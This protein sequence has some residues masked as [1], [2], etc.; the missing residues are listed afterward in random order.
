MSP[1]SWIALTGPPAECL[2][3]R[4][5][6][7]R[8]HHVNLP[9]NHGLA[10]AISSGRYDTSYFIS[11]IVI[12]PDPRSCDNSTNPPQGCDTRSWKKSQSYSWKAQTLHRDCMS[13]SITCLSADTPGFSMRIALP[14]CINRSTT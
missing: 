8:A 13:W 6:V 11:A 10:A 7:Y 4:R 5:A 9:E 14:D 2:N 1:S 12:F 3:L